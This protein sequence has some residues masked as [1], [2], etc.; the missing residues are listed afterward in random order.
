[1]PKIRIT[2]ITSFLKPPGFSLD[3]KK[4]FLPPNPARPLILDVSVIDETLEHWAANKWIKIQEADDKTPVIPESVTAAVGT[5]TKINEVVGS[6]FDTVEDDIFD[7]S[8]AKEATL[9]SDLVDKVGPVPLQPINQAAPRVKVSLGTQDSG[10]LADAVS[11]I[12]GDRPTPVDNSEAFTVRAPRQS[13]PGAVVKG[14]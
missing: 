3:Y 10:N 5:P 7:T 2:N 11:P 14:S 9:P 4:H 13:G 12:P 6:D 1:M 8:V